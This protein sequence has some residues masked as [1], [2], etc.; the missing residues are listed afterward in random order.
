MNSFRAT[1][2]LGQ[3]TEVIRVPGATPATPP[4]FAADETIP[5]RCVPWCSGGSKGATRQ[6]GTSESGAATPGVAGHGSGSASRKSLIS[7]CGHTVVS[8]RTTS[9]HSSPWQRTGHARGVPS[10]SS[11]PQV[12]LLVRRRSQPR[13]GDAVP[14][15]LARRRRRVQLDGP[16]LHEPRGH[17]DV[18]YPQRRE[19]LLQRAGLRVR[20][21]SEPRAC[22]RGR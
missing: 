19:V 7:G 12:A 5:A 10:A 3:Q 14:P 2:S 11:S 22:S 1:G 16:R 18:G 4:E 21:R 17:Q 13:G 20:R 6:V 8:T 9:G 15:E